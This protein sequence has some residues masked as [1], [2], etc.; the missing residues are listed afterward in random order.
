MLKRYVLFRFLK[1]YLLCAVSL[2][3]IYLVVD[4]FERVDEFVSRNAS[5]MD[6]VSYYFFK[7]PFV[8][9]YMAPQAVLLA[10]VIALASMARNNE[11]TAM[12]ACG[13]GVT[14]I[15]LP[16]VAAALGI[17]L[18]VVACNEYIAPPAS[19]KMNHVMYVKVRKNPNYGKIKQDDFWLRS[20]NNTIWNVNHYDP[21][22]K[23]MTGVSIFFADPG[24]FIRQR[25][26]AGRAVWAEG[27]WEF[28]DGAVRR[29]SG[30]G[31]EST[32]YFEKSYFPLHEQPEEFL[33][34]KVFKEELSVAEMYRDIQKQTALGNDTT[35]RWVDLHQKIS[36]PF[37]GL[38]MALM[39][40]PLSLRSSRRGGL[41]F[42][43]A[44]NLLMGF[45]FSFIYALGI[46]LGRGETLEP[47]LS[48]WGP[49]GLFLS[50]G[51][52]LILTLDSERLLPV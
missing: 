9:F 41:M 1:S 21:E 5:L 43:V 13:I 8:I 14:G 19:K 3:G 26:D 15:T 39:A 35:Q 38:V 16:V 37:I 25:I 11:F 12:K 48:A 2:I 44:V 18:L 50:L 45:A 31:L 30:E 46:S 6:T 27:R 34:R 32:E 51:F 49:I 22:A 10:T 29:F 33:E 23:V 24:Q 52:Y 4:F 36:Y 17:A 42:S 20:R 47:A 7:I 28:Q 40:I